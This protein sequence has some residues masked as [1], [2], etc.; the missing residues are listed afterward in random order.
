MG[1]THTALHYHIVFGTKG[2]VPSI[3]PDVQTRL[4]DYIAGIVRGETASPLPS[5]ECLITFTYSRPDIR[6]FALR[7]CCG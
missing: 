6:A 2:R 1:H 5:A 4:Y 7:T 3:Q